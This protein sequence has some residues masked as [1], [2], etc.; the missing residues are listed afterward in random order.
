MTSGHGK[1]SI[2][3]E[4]RDQGSGPC[5]WPFGLCRKRIPTKTK[6]VK[7]VSDYWKESYS[8][9]TEHTSRL[10][11]R[12][13]PHGSLHHFYVCKLINLR[14][15]SSRPPWPVILICLWFRVRYLRYVS[16]VSYVCGRLL[17]QDGSPEEAVGHRHQHHSRF[18]LHSMCSQGGLTLRRRTMDWLIFSL[19][20]A[21]PPAPVVCS[22]TPSLSPACNHIYLFLS[23]LHLSA[24]SSNPLS[25][26]S[27]LT[28]Y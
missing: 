1:E 14:G 7:H 13:S 3:S 22:G 26:L 28:D 4:P 18:D 8:M 24:H 21:Q 17:S 19:C 23:I 12:H 11:E 27:T 2:R 9:W 10:G 16:R 6:V 20:R 15:I 25:C 5:L